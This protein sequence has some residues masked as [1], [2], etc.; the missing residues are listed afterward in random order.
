MEVEPVQQGQQ[1]PVKIFQSGPQPGTGGT[2]VVNGVALLGGAL[3]VDPKPHLLSRFL[4]PL[5][6][7]PKLAG[8]V[9][10]KVVRV[11]EQ[12]VQLLLPV[13]RGKHVDLPGELLPA[14]AGLK[15]AAGGGTGQVPADQRV[16]GK[17]GEGLL[18]QEDL[19]AGLLG[20]D[21]QVFL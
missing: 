20:E 13:G 8:G 21:L 3:R 14:K 10:H 1:A 7:L 18:G 12:L 19:A 6:K 2:G 16:T 15:Q 9:E 5:S 4:G 17:H 11:G